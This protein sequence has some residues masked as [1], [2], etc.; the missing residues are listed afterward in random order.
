MIIAN[1]IRNY[2]D[3]IYSDWRFVTFD[4]CI[5][6]GT[7]NIFFTDNKSGFKKHLHNHHH[8]RYRNKRFYYI[9]SSEY[10]T[11]KEIKEMLGIDWNQFR[12]LFTRYCRYKWKKEQSL[13]IL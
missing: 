1:P 10:I 5:S 6:P 4:S 2:F 9:I 3:W 8:F 13:K 7:I 12:L 11:C